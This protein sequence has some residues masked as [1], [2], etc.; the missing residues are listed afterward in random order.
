MERNYGNVGV[1]DIR[2]AEEAVFADDFKIGNIGVVL[3]SKKT[4]P[5]LKHIHAGNI[6]SS[7]E[8]DKDIQL[9]TGKSVLSSQSLGDLASPLRMIVMGK[10][11]VL[12][13]L[14][15][16]ALNKGI[17][18]LE[19]SGKLVCPSDLLPIIQTKMRN[20]SGKIETYPAGYRLIE[21]NI[22]F[23]RT[24]I[25]ALSPKSRLAVFGDVSFD[26]NIPVQAVK[27]RLA[28]LFVRGSIHVP[29]KLLEV[30][31]ECL[32]SHA[33]CQVNV[34]PDDYEFLP[35]DMEIGPTELALWQGAKI[36]FGGALRF[37]ENVKVEDIEHLGAFTAKEA[38]YCKDSL[39]ATVAKKCDRFKT[40][41]VPY[42]DRLFL[43][44]GQ[45]ELSRTF[46]TQ[47]E[48]FLSIVNQGVLTI[49]PTIGAEE[50]HQRVDSIRNSGVLMVSDAQMGAV[51]A[52]AKESE[53]PILSSSKEQ[54]EAGTGNIGVLKL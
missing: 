38:V 18:F 35:E 49:D 34:I 48:G 30:L 17:E 29:E 5:L 6:G 50:I 20:L 44:V 33:S 37:S 19:V 9:V 54:G 7:I 10:L 45:G 43:N 39:L 41:F 15:A 12:E 11:V 46:L 1:L 8:C 51:Q 3:Y 21:K 42:R 31:Q 24:Q 13:D 40:R 14:N 25:L 52:K 22:Q 26:K 32:Q 4:A 47:G 16:E 28:G 27:E 53:G 2:D 23:D 36:V